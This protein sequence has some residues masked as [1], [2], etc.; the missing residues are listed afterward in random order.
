MISKTESFLRKKLS[1][2]EVTKSNANGFKNEE[3]SA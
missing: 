2:L 1:V 3:Y